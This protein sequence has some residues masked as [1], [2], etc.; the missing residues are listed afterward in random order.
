ME[1]ENEIEGG[2]FDGSHD[3]SKPFIRFIIL[4]QK[5][6]R[7][8]EYKKCRD[9]VAKNL[10]EKFDVLGFNRKDMGE[11]TADILDNVF[12][13]RAY[14]FMDTNDFRHYKIEGGKM[15]EI[16]SEEVTDIMDNAKMRFNYLF[17]KTFYG[18]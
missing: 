16:S 12:K 15:I 2:M 18:E 11:V 13:T 6:V 5:G 9:H 14:P 3:S 1:D 7:N 4:T 8:E 17:K 10:Q